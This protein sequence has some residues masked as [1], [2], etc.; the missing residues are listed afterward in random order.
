MRTKNLIISASFLSF[1]IVTSCTNN[2][3]NIDKSE[4]DSLTTDTLSNN[5]NRLNF[6]LISEK[7][8]Y[9]DL[10]EFSID[11]L[12]WEK[13]QEFYTKLDSTE[14]FQIYQG[15]NEIPYEDLDVDYLDLDF[16]FSKQSN[17]RGLI[18]FTILNQ[19]EGVYCDKIIYNIYSEDGEL[20]SSFE[21]AGN[22]GDGGYYELSNGKFLNDSTYELLTTDNYK[23]EDIEMPNTIT[24]SKTI[25]TIKHNGQITQTH[26]ILKTEVE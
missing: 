16:F 25:T 6:D 2:S 7:F 26:S 23:T 17:K 1:V 8:K 13:R 5:S 3:T 10:K 24:F 14:F 20:I 15:S 4:K 12:Q 22:C 19:R 21:V 11:T 18:E 9:Q